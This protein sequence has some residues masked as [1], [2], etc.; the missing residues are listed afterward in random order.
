VVNVSD[1]KLTAS[2]SEAYVTDI[3]KGDKVLVNIPELKEEFESRVT[4]VGKT[5][6]PLS[7]TFNVEVKLTPKPSLRPNM[8]GIIR[9]VYHTEPDA[10]TVPIN[11][12][13]DL[14]NEKIVYVAEAKGKQTVA[15]KKVV[16]VEGVFDG[17][18]QVSGLSAGDKVITVGYQGLNDG[19]F[20]K[21]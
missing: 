20:V 9:V 18:A 14:N 11:I 8:T 6:D 21:I 5:I 2:V 3:K 1:L 4:F 7:R 13:Q 15:R 16:N 19:D 10:I 12:V 17:R